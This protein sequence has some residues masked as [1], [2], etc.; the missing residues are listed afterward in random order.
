[1]SQLQ[2]VTIRIS[3]QEDAPYLASWLADPKIL[4]WFPLDNSREIE[5]AVK[6]WLSYALY[7]SA[8]TGCIDGVPCGM[9][10]LYLHRYKKLKHQVSEDLSSVKVTKN[11]L[12]ETSL[13]PLK[14]T[15]LANL[16]EKINLNIN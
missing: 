5:D 1:M 2:E 7:E 4:C 10:V 11:R 3:Q 16:K 8:Y 15:Y 9:A 14:L 12:I 6:I 13:L